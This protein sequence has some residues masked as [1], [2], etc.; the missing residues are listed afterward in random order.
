MIK[1]PCKHIERQDQIF[2]LE[3]NRPYLA[4]Y[5]TALKKFK[6]QFNGNSTD[7]IQLTQAIPAPRQSLH[8]ANI[9]SLISGNSWAISS[10]VFI[11]RAVASSMSWASLWA[12]LD[13]PSLLPFFF[14]WLTK[15][16]TCKQGHVWPLS[17]KGLVYTCTLT[18][19]L[20]VFQE[21]CTLLELMIET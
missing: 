1:I 2:T 19:I 9:S 6:K 16:V 7:K 10:P 3:N 20:L 13:F 8:A 21:R 15:V 4:S 12:F 17:W 14:G 5:S 11:S 18:E